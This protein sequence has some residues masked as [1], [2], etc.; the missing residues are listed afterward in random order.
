[1][2]GV[3]DRSCYFLD[4][5]TFYDGNNLYTFNHSKSTLFRKFIIPP[6]AFRLPIDII[7]D[8]YSPIPSLNS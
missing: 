4:C 2:V 8:P 1:M 5:L 3:D 6:T 7:E